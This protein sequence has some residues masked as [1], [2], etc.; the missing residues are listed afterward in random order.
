MISATLPSDSKLGGALA[1]I[2]LVDDEP[3]ILEAFACCLAD[4]GFAVDTVLSA[5]DALDRLRGETF[6][7]VVIDVGLPGLSGFELYRRVQERCEIPVIFCTAADTLSDRLTGFDLGADDYVTKP[8]A[9][10][11][12]VRRVR[13]VLRRT[14]GSAPSLIGGPNGSTLDLE[15]REVRAAD[16]SVQLTPREWAVLLALLRR[17]GQVLSADALALAGWGHPTFGERNFVEAQISRLRAKLEQIGVT[18][19]IRTVRAA[20]YLIA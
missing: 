17:R 5:E 16:G 13:A 19:A 9:L 20:G 15:T 4:E 18:H 8:V 14:Q 7:L 3:F 12:M 1:R 2:L 6:D 10:A 11:E